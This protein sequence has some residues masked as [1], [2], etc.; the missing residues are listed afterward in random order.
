MDLL[1]ALYSEMSFMSYFEHRDVRDSVGLN[2][3]QG[4][5]AAEIS[6]S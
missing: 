1:R 6:T 4:K 5:R 3:A 2:R